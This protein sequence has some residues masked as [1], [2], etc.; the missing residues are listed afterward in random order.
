[1]KDLRKKTRSWCSEPYA[2]DTHAL[3]ATRT[4]VGSDEPFAH[5]SF[6]YAAKERFDLDREGQARGVVRDSGFEAF[7]GQTPSCG[8]WPAGS[9][10]GGARWCICGRR[11]ED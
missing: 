3:D 1:L 7:D 6:E 4:S 8:I 9:S 11:P 5:A 2:D 10:W